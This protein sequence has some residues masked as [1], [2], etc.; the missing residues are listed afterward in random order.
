MLVPATTRQYDDMPRFALLPYVPPRIMLLTSTVAGASVAA[1]SLAGLPLWAIAIAGVVPWFPVFSHETIWTWRNYGWLAIFY[2]LAI[3]QTGH[4]A[5]HLAQMV[6][7]H[8]LGQTGQDARG[9]VSTL[10][11]EWVHLVWNGWVV[12]AAGVLVARF[13]TNRWLWL[14]VVGSVVAVR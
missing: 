14:S 3:S 12:L 9:V 1:G 2:V 13:R 6:Q 7:I 4:F 11:V 5:E 8:I 10:D